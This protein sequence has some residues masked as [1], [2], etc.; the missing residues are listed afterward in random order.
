M[1]DQNQ[2]EFDPIFLKD[3]DSNLIHVPLFSVTNDGSC[4]GKTFRKIPTITFL[5]FEEKLSN[6][7]EWIERLDRVIQNDI[8]CCPFGDYWAAQGKCGIQCQGYSLPSLVKQHFTRVP[9]ITKRGIVDQRIATYCFLSRETSEKMTVTDI[10][11]SFSGHDVLSKVTISNV[12]KELT[13]VV[14]KIYS[15][16]SWENVSKKQ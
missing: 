3:I 12:S 16:R 13:F 1:G 8:F 9:V 5:L 15:Y 2:I 6:D 7:R 14:F 4:S 11:H 10:S